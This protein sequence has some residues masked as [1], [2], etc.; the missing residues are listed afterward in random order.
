MVAAHAVVRFHVA[1]DGFAG[2]PAFEPFS[3]RAAEFLFASPDPMHARVLLVG[4]GHDT[5]C[6]RKPP[7]GCNGSG[8]SLGRW[9]FSGSGRRRGSRGSP[10]RRRSSFSFEVLT[11]PTL[12]PNSYFFVRL[13]FGGAL[14]LGGLDAVD[15]PLVVL[16]PGVDSPR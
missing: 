2:R 14:H 7:L 5:P 8:A 11:T 1:A 12:Q 4:H 16:L 6:R 15:F 3:Q 9:R 13:A 10:R